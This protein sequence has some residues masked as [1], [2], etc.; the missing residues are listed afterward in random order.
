[1]PKPPILPHPLD[2]L[3]QIR[4]SRRLIRDIKRA[5]AE[6]GTTPSAL[7]RVAICAWLYSEA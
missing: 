5:A 1:M 6:R 7:I 2:A 3:I 4:A